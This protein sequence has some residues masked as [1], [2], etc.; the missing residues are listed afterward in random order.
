HIVEVENIRLEKQQGEYRGNFTFDVSSSPLVAVLIIGNN[1]RAAITA[2]ALG[3][4]ACVPGVLLLLYN[5]RMLGTLAGLVTLH[6]Y[7]GDFAALI[8]THGV[9]E[10]TAICIAG[11][12]GF[13]L[14]WALISPG[15]FT[16]REAL[17]RAAG[18]AFGLLGGAAVLLVIAGHIE[19]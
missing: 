19:A 18:D 1:V 10:L 17:R 7:L 4:L 9:L 11:G 2:F 12:A 14:G 15:Q 5:G 13:I 8:L 6:G 16:R 3:A